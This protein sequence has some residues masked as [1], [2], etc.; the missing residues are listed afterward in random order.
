MQISKLRKK[1]DIPK[2][3]DSHIDQDFPGYPHALSKYELINPKTKTEKKI[4]RVDDKDGEKMNQI[5]K[6]KV[7]KNEQQSEGSANAFGGTE[8]V[9]DD[10]DVYRGGDMGRKFHRC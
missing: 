9:K 2:T 6:K 7:V 10:E 3:P 5:E 1:K 8:S 4:A